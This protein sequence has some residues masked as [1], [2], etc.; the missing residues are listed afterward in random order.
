MGRRGKRSIVT[1]IAKMNTTCLCAL[2]GALFFALGCAGPR[3][4]GPLPVTPEML[5]DAVDQLAPIEPGTLRIAL[6]FAGDTDLDL[7]VTD[8]NLDSVHFA[9]P[10]GA[11]GGRFLADR[12]CGDPAPRVEMIEWENVCPGIF[13]I[14]IEHAADC[15]S[16]EAEQGILALS[17]NNARRTPK[18]IWQLRIDHEGVEFKEG[19][20]EANAFLPIVFEVKRS[21]ASIPG[22]RR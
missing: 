9:R 13:E 16:P 22:C 17:A 2:A 3:I 6:A 14:S 18:R 20:I 8:A 12:G 4:E 10:L 11:R 15:A 1:G 5:R 21:G 7:A 19:R